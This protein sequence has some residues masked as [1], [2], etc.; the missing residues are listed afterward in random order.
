MSHCYTLQLIAT[1]T[2]TRNNAQ[3]V[4]ETQWPLNL[5][6]PQRTSPQ[7]TWMS[8][9][10]YPYIYMEVDLVDLSTWPPMVASEEMEVALVDVSTWP[11]RHVSSS[12]I[13]TLLTH[14]TH[15]SCRPSRQ[16]DLTHLVDT[17]PPH[18]SIR[19]DRKVDQSRSTSRGRRVAVDLSTRRPTAKSTS[20]KSGG[21]QV[22]KSPSCGGQQ[23]AKCLKR[24]LRCLQTSRQVSQDK[25]PQTPSV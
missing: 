18:S 11:S 17:S 5:W 15:L 13:Y 6:P 2:A 21:R 7:R 4:S 19:G 25:T 1:R 22:A 8:A 16:V 14:L 9:C 20:R 12:L 23:V 3:Q 24:C 10:T